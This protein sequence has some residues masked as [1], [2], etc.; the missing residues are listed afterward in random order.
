MDVEGGWYR[1]TFTDPAPRETTEKMRATVKSEDVTTLL[2][3]TLPP[4][5]PTPE[6]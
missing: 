2:P 5:F 6:R 4:L 1:V 3:S